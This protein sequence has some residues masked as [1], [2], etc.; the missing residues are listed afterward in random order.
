MMSEGLR[1]EL[2]F[3]DAVSLVIGTIVGA[4][5]YIVAAYGAGSLGPASILSWIIGGLMAMVLALVFSEASAIMPRTGG[6]Y[7]YAREALG[8]FAGFITGW[9]LWVSS[10]IAIAVFPVAFVYYI[11]QFIGLSPTA[12]ALIKV[13][14]I[15]SLTA[16]N[17]S[18]VGRAGKV[19]DVLTV[20]KIAPLILLVVTGILRF[21]WDP[22]GLLSGYTPFAPMGL[23]AL[24]SVTVLVF[25]AYVGFELVTVPAGEVKNPGRIIPL[26]IIIG[27]VFVMVFY[28]LTNFVI[29]GLV[30]WGVLASSP[31]PLTLAG[32]SALGG[33]G[34]LILTLGALISI[35]GSEEAG[36]LT[37]ARL[38]H[39]MSLDGF[40]PG[41]LSRIH[42]RFRTPHLS[43]LVQNLTALVAALTGTAAGL[44]ELSV[45]TLL[46]AYMST[47]V[48]LPVLRRR[49]Y[50]D[51]GV[52]LKSILGVLICLYLLANTGTGTIL[53]GSLL[54]V[55]GVP[56]YLRYR[57]RNQN[58]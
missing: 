7:S 47:C 31:A 49:R 3:F 27:M 45:L 13:I 34:A 53:A 33:A 18:G 42:P 8:E 22:S 44:I 26:A 32:Y 37:T 4:D 17:I 29:L 30:P 46:L 58:L 52:P 50:R 11:S 43:I 25:W 41:W 20:L 6:P 1:R 9:S 48:S 35:A 54:I 2:T 39:V 14:F 5:I 56:I 23:G 55:A 57:R 16:I 24:G 19:N 21:I 36:M 38:L 51:A 15:L 28:L 12:E 10:W 40:L